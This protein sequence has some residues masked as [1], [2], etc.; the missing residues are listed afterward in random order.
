MPS[1]FYAIL[2]SLYRKAPFFFL[3][4]KEQAQGEFNVFH[5]QDQAT[6]TRQSPEAARCLLLGDVIPGSSPNIF[7]SGRY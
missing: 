6:G 4:G 3:Q 7:I 5:A 2:L 1:P